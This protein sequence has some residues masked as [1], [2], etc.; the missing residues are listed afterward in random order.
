ME[1]T[2]VKEIENPILHRKAIHFEI[3]HQNKGSPNRLEVR[4]KIAAMQT[5]E[6]DLTFIKSMT[7]TFGLPKLTGKALIYSDEKV[8]SELEPT[9]SRIRNMPKDQRDDS[10]K[11]IKAKKKGK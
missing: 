9:Y 5:A 10:W 11:E 3:L 6:P 4:D 8:A 1:I 7:T 2:I